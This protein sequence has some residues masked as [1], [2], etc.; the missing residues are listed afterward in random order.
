MH[1]RQGSSES[2]DLEGVR[3]R[4]A[5][6]LAALFERHFDQLYALAYRLLGDHAA[7][8]DAVH[9]VFLKVHRSADRLDVTREPG[10][11]L[12]RIATNV[13][14]DHWRSGAQRLA[15]ASRSIE[16]DPDLAQTLAGR[17]DDPE[18]DALASERSDL[19]RRAILK[20]KDP[21]REVVVLREYLDLDYDEIAAIT[22]AKA[23][24]V[25]KRHSRALAELGSALRRSGL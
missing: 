22:G 18:S 15:R 10:P 16:A 5:G 7:A 12:I 17:A 8:E 6:A 25:R 24:A 13:C 4:D 19:V 1:R 2:L 3:R 11:W 14:R 23:A 20:L 21:L 9:D